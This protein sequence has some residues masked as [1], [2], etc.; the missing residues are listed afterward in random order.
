LERD[1]RHHGSGSR[2]WSEEA[3][4]GHRYLTLVN[5]LDRSRVL[6]VA[7]DRKQSSLDGFW[8]TLTEEQRD[9]IKAVAIFG[10]DWQ[11]FC[12]PL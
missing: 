2:A 1:P 3:E 4:S 11:E 10:A 7:E 5:D 12:F 6:Y 8:P 9:G